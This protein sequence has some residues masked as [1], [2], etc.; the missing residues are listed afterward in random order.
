[1][2]DPGF[3]S[4]VRKDREILEKKFRVDNFHYR[5][6]KNPVE[7]VIQIMRLLAASLR[8]ATSS[9]L[10]Y[11][12][13]ADYHSLIPALIAKSFGKKVVV[14][15]GGFDAVSIPMLSYGVFVKNNF[16][17]W[18]ASTTYKLADLVLPVDASLAEGLN[19]YA[20]PDG[21][22]LPVG[23]RNFVRNLRSRI[24]VLPTGYNPDLWKRHTGM[25]RNASVLSV[26]FITKEQTFKLKGFDLL[27]ETARL[28]PDVPFTL[29]GIS[30]HIQNK[31]RNILPHNVSLI[32]P[33]PYHELPKLYSSHKVYA[34]LSLSEGLPNS[35]CEAMLCECVPVGSLVNGIPTAIGNTGLLLEH[36]DAQKTAELISKALKTDEQTGIEARN[37]IIR[38]FPEHRRE[39]N[40]MKLL[41]EIL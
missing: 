35:L 8:F 17:S 28:L 11:I 1:M 19:Q 6:S 9:E 3:S 5:A 36:Q 34:Q 40:L 24:E 15:T 31:Y 41:E 4:F 18:C 2:V 7:F 33:V 13:F 37:Q 38:N 32:D 14:V 30:P 10:V 20:D 22:G 12:W 26:A 27:I 21:K 29:A 39:E 23:I 25:P 16:R